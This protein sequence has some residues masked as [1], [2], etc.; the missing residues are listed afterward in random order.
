[1]K[2][3]A[4]ENHMHVHSNYL[5]FL[6]LAFSMVIVL[7]NWFDPRLITFFGLTTDAGTLIF[8]CTFLLSDLITEVYGYKFARRAIWCGFLFN[9]IYILYGQIIIHMPSPSYKTNNQI[10]DSLLAVDARIIFA[11]CMSYL[12]SEPL[13][14]F[15]M[16]KIKIKMNGRLVGLRFLSSTIVAS[17]V[18][19]ALFTF[20]AFYGSMTN[21]DLISLAATMWLI[22]IS[23]ELLGLPLSITLSNKLKVKEKIDMYDKG[24]RFNIFSLDTE[25]KNKNNSYLHTST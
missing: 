6:T 12:C 2:T 15:L 10:F 22:K 11:S 18:D 16:A 23:I 1:M 3:Q 14:S 13:N 4:L 17:A 19:S 24:T 7:S 8:P 25:Y 9:A 20:L 21:H 5:W